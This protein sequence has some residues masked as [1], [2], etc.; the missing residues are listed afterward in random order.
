MKIYIHRL[1]IASAISALAVFVF[2]Q[3][4]KK[5]LIA[6]RGA[7]AYAPEHTVEAY[8]LAI[9]QG[10]DFV[11]QDLQITKDGVLVCLHD[12]TLERTTDVEEVFPDRFRADVSEDQPP[13]GQPV[14]HWYVSDFTLSEIKRLDAGSWFNAKFKGSRVQ[15]FQE[16][17]DLVRGKAGLYPE[18]K[19]PE[20]YGKR[21]FDMERLVIEVLKK[22]RLDSPGADP[23]TPVIIQSFSPESLRKM[24]FELKTKLPLILLITGD[25][26]NKWLSADGMKRIKEF[27]DGVGPVKGLIEHNP[28]IVRWAHDAGLTVTPW[29][30]RSDS[31]GRFKDAREEM[32]HFLFDYGVDA[33][34]TNNPDLFPRS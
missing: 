9:E 1:L 31:I 15:T 19:A 25:S 16:A 14:K 17:I 32:R 23:K 28:E 34:F 24:R 13:G 21:G 3:S 2:A 29:T 18:T 6:H 33:L 30:F 5:I 4:G 27:A 22:N 10:A 20:V 26:Q 7:S 8:R 11:E 12:L